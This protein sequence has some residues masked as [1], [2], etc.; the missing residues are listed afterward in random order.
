[1]LVEGKPVKLEP[2]GERQ[3]V[4]GHVVE[5]LVRDARDHE[6]LVRLDRGDRL[7]GLH[8]ADDEGGEPDVVFPLR[9]D[10]VPSGNDEKFRFLDAG[11][12]TMEQ[13]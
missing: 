13:K 6:L 12:R 7:E 3:H 9:V 8:V 5:P 1:M 4:H 11:S 10:V 2:A